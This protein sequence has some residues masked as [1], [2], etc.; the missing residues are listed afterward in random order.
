MGLFRKREPTKNEKNAKEVMKM[1]TTWGEHYYAWNGRL[2]DSDI[3]RSCIRPK[4]KAVG[5]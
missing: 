2:Y 5:K 3:V 1:V 4:V